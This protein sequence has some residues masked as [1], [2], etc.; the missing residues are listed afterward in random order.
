MD[1]RQFEEIQE[2]RLPTL[3]EVL[4]QKTSPPVDL[5]T[6]YTYLSQFPYAINYLDF[7]I[8]LMA[9]TRLCK[10]YINIVRR[11]LIEESRDRAEDVQSV[12][13]SVLM[14]TLMMEGEEANEDN[15]DKVRGN[16]VSRLLEEWARDNRFGGDERLFNISD[17]NLPNLMDEFLQSVSRNRN[18]DNGDGEDRIPYISCKQ[19][20]NNARHLIRMYIESDSKSERYLSNIPESMRDELIQEVIMDGK[21]DPLIFHDL[22]ELVYQFLEIDCFPKFLSQ[23]GLH[24]LH[25]EISD[26]RFHKIDREGNSGGGGTYNGS[27]TPFSNY[28]I[29][30][31]IIFGLVWLWIGLWIGYTLIFLN[32][33]RSLRVVTVVP[34][35]LS[36]YYIICGLYQVDIIYTWFG[37]TQRIMY[38]GNLP[39]NEN[40]P[41]KDDKRDDDDIPWIFILFGGRDRLI[42]VRHPFI[43][44]LL[45]RRG[46]WCTLLVV[47]FTACLTVIFSCVPGRRL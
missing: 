38:S 42:R 20:M 26:W 40:A 18:N 47:L 13:T 39:T 16:K 34:F 44:R 24:N 29:L 30:S 7:W 21:Y 8:D 9:H 46:L 35:I 12:T 19:L 11:S 43:K 41:N 27:R 36:M 32:Y 3:Y 10:D 45:I 17:T 6:F 14:N 4:I 28:T 23:V 31:R 33:S 5:W 2:A 15:E 22:K 1:V 25:D 37:V